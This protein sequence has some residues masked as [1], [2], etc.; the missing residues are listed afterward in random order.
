MAIRCWV[1]LTLR[2]KS[3]KNLTIKNVT[4]NCGK[5]YQWNDDTK[6]LGKETV[7]G[8]TIRAKKDFSF[9]ACGRENG[10]MG[11]AADF[12]LYDGETKVVS[13]YYSC[14]YSGSNELV[15]KFGED[16]WMVDVPKIMT[17][18]SLGEVLVKVA[19]VGDE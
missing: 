10:T 6:E 2:N 3:N 19:F 11:C 8:Q 12:D 7:E 15:K 13:L 17:A 14:P 18:G 4:V 5:F 9:A 1:R 16:D